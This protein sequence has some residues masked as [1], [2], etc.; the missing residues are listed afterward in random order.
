[1][2]PRYSF[3]RGLKSRINEELKELKTKI[4][5]SPENK[6]NGPYVLTIPL[7]GI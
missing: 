3:S 6:I 7:L 2:F 1:M 4:I 5:N